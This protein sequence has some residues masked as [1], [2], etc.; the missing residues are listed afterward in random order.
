MSVEM[1]TYNQTRHDHEITLEKQTMIEVCPDEDAGPV[2][3]QMQYHVCF[4]PPCVALAF[5]MRSSCVLGW[6]LW[7]CL[8]YNVRQLTHNRL[9]VANVYAVQENRRS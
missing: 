6:L 4:F 9:K 5:V 2:I 3:P 8:E 7:T 1:Q